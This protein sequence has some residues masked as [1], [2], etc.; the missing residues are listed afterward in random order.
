[1]G[2]GGYASHE[3]ARFCHRHRR[4]ATLVSRFHGDANLYAPP[5]Q[6]KGQKGRPRVKGKKLP[7]PAQVVTHIRRAKATVRWYGGGDRR[8]QW[9]SD[10]GHWYK[11]GQ[12]LVPI[13]WVF[14]HD[15]Q[16]TH[17]DEYLYTTDVALSGPQIVSLFTARWPIE[18][19]FQEMRAHLGFETPLV[20]SSA[21]CPPLWDAGGGQFLGTVGV[22]AAA[23][24]RH[25]ANRSPQDQAG[26][27]GLAAGATAFVVPR[28]AKQ[29]FQ[30]IVGTRQIGD[31]VTV[32]QARH[33]TVADFEEVPEQRLQ[34]VRLPG[35]T[36]H[37][38]QMGRVSPAYRLG[39]G[40][41]DV[42]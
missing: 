6:R 36:T 32:E 1:L 26:R 9:V 39:R 16:G 11:G 5:L 19:T 7:T 17:R 24:A 8:V 35:Q 29:L 20:Q 40:P 2:D 33:V 10:V 18:T 4:H 41:A 21:K 25:D 23:Q 13:R 27:S 38:P 14:V 3:L 37:A 12:G 28:G 42:A 22:L 30:R 31:L 15:A 34:F